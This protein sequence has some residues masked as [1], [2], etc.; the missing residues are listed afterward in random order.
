MIS[1]TTF[2]ARNGALV[3]HFHKQEKLKKKK[4]KR[5]FEPEVAPLCPVFVNEKNKKHTRDLEGKGQ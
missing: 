1:K 3:S 5:D 2:R 4:H